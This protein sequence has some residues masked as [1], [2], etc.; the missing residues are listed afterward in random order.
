M[1]LDRLYGNRKQSLIRVNDQPA[2][3]TREKHYEIK[4][5]SVCLVLYFFL[6]F[7]VPLNEFVSPLNLTVANFTSMDGL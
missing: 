2:H 5:I 3:H 1:G 7:G 4:T 6:E